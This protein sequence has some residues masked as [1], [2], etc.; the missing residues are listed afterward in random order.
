MGFGRRGQGVR[1]QDV[2]RPVGL[3]HPALGQQE[4]RR[5]RQLASVQDDQQGGQGEEHERPPPDEIV[6]T[7]AG[8][9]RAEQQEEQSVG[10][11]VADP[12]GADVQDRDDRSPV[13]GRDHLRHHRDA[14]GELAAE[15]DTHDQPAGQQHLVVRG[16][17]ADQSADAV[18]DQVQAQCGAASPT[19]RQPA[20]EEAAEEAAEHRGGV[21]R[22]QVGVV[23][24]QARLD[25]AAHR[26]DGVLLEGVEEHAG[27]DQHH[28][29]ELGA[30]EAGTVQRG[31]HRGGGCVV[32]TAVQSH[33]YSSR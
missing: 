11:E 25:V 27:E 32:R 2:Q 17:G 28:H 30:G 31:R 33:G 21:D 24:A 12:A 16:D 10:D 13:A 6:A 9:Q 1:D 3:L 29:P 7:E 15:A 14:D 22:G 5:L 19:V 18:D 20:A 4:P 26:P 8:G 23:D